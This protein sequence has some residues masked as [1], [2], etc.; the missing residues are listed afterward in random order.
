M[1]KPFIV[2]EMSGNHLGGL[3]Q[4]ILLVRTAANTGAS[5]IKLQTFDP[6]E[7]VG[8]PSYTIPSGPWA[9]RRLIDVYRETHTPRKWH[10]AL[11]DEARE[12]GIEAFSTPFSKA[13]VD[14]L[15][16][17][18]PPRYKIA[19]FEL[20]DL[21]LI[22]YVASTGKPV[23]LSTGMASADEIYEAVDAAGSNVTVMRCTSA[24]PAQE[25]DAGL[26]TMARIPQIF[27]CRFG[28]SDHTPGIGVAVG[29]VALGASII[30]KHLTMNRSGGGPDAS[31]SL[32]PQEFA[33]LVTECHRAAA[34]RT[35]PNF[36]TRDSERPQHALRRS[37]FFAKHLSAGRIITADAVRTARP[38]LG[39]P[40]RELSN[41]IGKR[42]EHSVRPGQPVTWDVIHQSGEKR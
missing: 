41:V 4:A 17:F 2:A 9:G 29:A 7:M 34:A 13:D 31:F 18:D 24:Y 33:S 28:L 32:E 40:P 23:I 25:S 38:A 37:L 1:S 6:N 21:P 20:V 30:E 26:L 27:G 35:D 22:R 3:A 10:K 39:L 8:D 15:E 5:A 12:C 14:F 36:C 19:S 16:L 42:L 11:F